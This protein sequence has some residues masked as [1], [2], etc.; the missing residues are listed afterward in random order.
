MLN[1][2]AGMFFEVSWEVCNKVGGIFTVISSKAAQ[3]QKYYGDGYFLVG[4][5]FADK[6]AGQFMEEVPPDSMK[7]VCDEL[8]KHGIA[9]HYG[10]WLVKGEP[11]VMLLDFMGFSQQT[12]EIKRKL[13]DDYQIDSLGTEWYGFDEPVV[14][15]TA[16]GKLLER[17]K[18]VHNEDK[19]VAQ[20]H[21][22]LSGAALLYLK[23][24][25][26]DIGTVFTTHATMLG[27]T[28][29]SKDFDLYGQLK[30]IDPMREAYNNGIQAKHLTEMKCAQHAD[31]L[32]TV[33]EITGIEA[34]H[35]LGKKPDVILPNG[36]DFDKFP[37][38]EDLSLK[39][40]IMREKIREFIMYYFFPFYQFDL[41]KTL[42]YFLAGRYEF[43][44]KGIDLFVNAL[45]KLNNRLKKEKS[46]RTIIAFFWVPGPIRGIKPS[47]LQNKTL[48]RDIKDALDVEMITVEKSLLYS[49]VSNK[50]VTKKSLF[51]EDFLH[52]AKKKILRFNQKGIPPLLTHD[53]YNEDQDQILNALK[54]VGLLNR[55]EDRV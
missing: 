46:D 25:K 24:N 37:S 23:T 44:D 43:H 17:I 32:T 50:E 27:R 41:K 48:F 21:E 22:W 14:W 5:Y 42:F 12:N 18:Q 1:P 29:A 6:A 45:G 38:F 53:L 39:H 20:F 47:L 36:L 40:K 2:K 55:K 54:S 7:K 30:N 34:T 52:E 11:K 49:V 16:V 31:I 26:V 3:M 9:V 51:S 8:N 19:I 10:K 15:S 13:W 4:P 35:L 33:R 28:L